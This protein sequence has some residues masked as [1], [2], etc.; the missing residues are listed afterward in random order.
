M[1]RIL[2]IVEDF[3]INS[4]GLRTV[5]KNLDFYLKQNNIKSYILS[6]NKEIEDEIFTIKTSRFGYYS[7]GWYKKI[8]RIVK[9][10][11][12]NIIHIHGVWT[13]PNYIAGRYAIDNNI[14]YVLSPH[15]MYEPYIW[16]KGVIKKKIYFKLIAVN[17]FRKATIFHS[18]T[19]QETNNIKSLFNTKNIVELPNLIAF[20]KFEE[21]LELKE[22]YI[23]FLGRINPKKGL[24]LLIN[25]LCNIKTHNVKLKIAGGF[26]NHKIKLENII[27]NLNLEDKVEF[28]GQVKGLEK[29]N[30]IKNAWVMVA[31]SYSEVI[32]MVNLEA[33]LFKTPMITTYQTGLLQEWNK[34]GGIL[35]NPNKKELTLAMQQ[36]LNWTE[37]ERKERG[38]KL[39][40]FVKENYS[41]KERIRDWLNLYE[42]VLKK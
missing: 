15:G 1:I 25:S 2:H 13:Y 31:P 28:L 8:E 9:S 6:S 3:S 29:E 14:P 34:N 16:S 22:K 21:K 40:K 18:I 23:L 20:S 5:V 32:G 24:E 26:N 39:H 11:N 19:N 7:K 37:K 42:K 36:A 17:V 35:I 27:K 10:N 38:E 12:I 41:W 33:G 30:L 4:G